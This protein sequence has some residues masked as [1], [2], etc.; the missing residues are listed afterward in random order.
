MG[1]RRKNGLYLRNVT[2]EDLKDL[3][4]T[5]TSNFVCFSVFYHS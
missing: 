5:N 1:N 2:R 3:V 4:D